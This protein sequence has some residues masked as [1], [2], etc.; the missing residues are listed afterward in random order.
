M[1]I[2]IE[3]IDR[4]GKTT[5]AHMLA[6]ELAG[7]TVYR[8][9]DRQHDPTGAEIDAFL[10][11]SSSLSPREAHLLFV[12]NR[13]GRKVDIET[14]T[15]DVIVDRWSYSGVAYAAAEEQDTMPWDWLCECESDLPRPDVVIYLDLAP[16]V[17]ASRADFGNE[18]YDDV[19][20]LHKVA[21]N[22]RRLMTPTWVVID[23]TQPAAEVHRQVLAAVQ[24]HKAN[25]EMDA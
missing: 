6:K 25:M 5:Q 24:R 9:P 19:A 7:S 14:A 16:E 21:H 10:R 12:A 15:C 23:A 17:A 4:S 3:G 8:F 13:A 1:F 18:R 2:A 20:V 11:G 22:F